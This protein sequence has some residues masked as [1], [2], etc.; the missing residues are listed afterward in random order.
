MMSMGGGWFFLVAAEAISVLNNSYT[1]P[2]IGAYAGA[3]IDAGDLGKVT[4]AIVTMA[5]MVI[6]VN[7]LFWQPAGRVVGEI[8]ERAVRSR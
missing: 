1:L 8:Q 4:L 3:A 7:V 5:V 2:G 6:G